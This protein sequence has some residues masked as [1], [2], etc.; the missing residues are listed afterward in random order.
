MMV[1]GRIYS[2]VGLYSSVHGLDFESD[3]APA[4]EDFFDV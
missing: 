1:A 2:G 4:L 3:F